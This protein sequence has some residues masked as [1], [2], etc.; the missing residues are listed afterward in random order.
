M[1]HMPL[2]LAPSSPVR[3]GAVEHERD[4]G[5]VQRD[6]HEHL[7]EGAVEERRVDGDHGVQ[8]AERHAGRRRRGVLL[9]DADVEDARGELGGERR[10]PDRLEHRGRD[11]DDVRAATADPHDLVGE[12][13]GPAEPGRRQR[14]AGLG[15]D[16]ADRVEPVGDV[17]L[18]GRVAAA[19]LGDDVHD[20]G[21]AERLRALRSARSTAGC[22]GRRPGRGT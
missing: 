12:H 5:L 8:A 9:G 20:D 14:Q 15:V 11:R 2:W 18:G 1:S 7:V 13:A 3:P 19:L 21:S 4:A 17:L 16:P 22:R 6:V 10:E